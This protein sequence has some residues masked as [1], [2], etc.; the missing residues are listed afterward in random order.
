MKL[1]DR[2]TYVRGD[3]SYVPFASSFLFHS[4][5][6]HRRRKELRLNYRSDTF[7]MVRLSYCSLN[8]AETEVST[9]YGILERELTV[10][11]VV[12]FS[13]GRFINSSFLANSSSPIVI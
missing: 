11:P 5:S 1:A 12:R 7:D 13:T 8:L 4:V 6:T 9:T 2:V 3:P 10:F